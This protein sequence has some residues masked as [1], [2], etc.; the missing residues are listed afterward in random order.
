[1]AAGP[2]AHAEILEILRTTG[3]PEDY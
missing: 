2:A 1:L 3:R